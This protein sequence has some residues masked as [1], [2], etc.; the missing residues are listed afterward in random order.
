MNESI[1]DTTK[2]D[3]KKEVAKNDG[4][5]LD[6]LIAIGVTSGII[7]IIAWYPMKDVIGIISLFMVTMILTF[8]ISRQ[9]FL[10]EDYGK[11]EP[12]IPLGTLIRT[13]TIVILLVSL[14]KLK[15]SFKARLNFE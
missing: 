6:W 14:L 11:K 3:G 1:K 12:N 2:N 5:N 8:F 13:A 7:S 10:G 9:S 4:K 15:E